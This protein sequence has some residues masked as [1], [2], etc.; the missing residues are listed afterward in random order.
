MRQTFEAKDWSQIIAKRSKALLV[1]GEAK[2]S[3]ENY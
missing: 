2:S 1:T 3:V